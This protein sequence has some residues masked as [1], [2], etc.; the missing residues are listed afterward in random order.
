MTPFP[1]YPGSGVHVCVFT[2]VL[3]LNDLPTEALLSTA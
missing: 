2:T 1:G 3:Y